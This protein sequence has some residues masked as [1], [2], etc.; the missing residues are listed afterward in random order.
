[1]VAETGKMPFGSF[2]LKLVGRHLARSIVFGQLE[3][4]LLAFEKIAHPGAFDGADMN[5][6]VL[7]TIVRLDEAEAFLAVEPFDCASAHDEPLLA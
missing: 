2:G 4:D 5:E 7:T 1:V 6:Y 3:A